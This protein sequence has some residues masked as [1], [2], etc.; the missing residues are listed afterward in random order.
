MGLTYWGLVSTP[1][2]FIPQQDMGYL[3][4]SVQ[5]PDASSKE[6]TEAVMKR[7]V[8][9]AK[10]TPGVWHATGVTGQSFVLNAFGSNFGSMFVNLEDYSERRDPTRYPADAIANHLRRSSPSSARGA[11][12]GVRS[13]AGARRGPG[14]R[15]HADGRGPRRR[16]LASAAGRD[17]KP[18][19]QRANATPGLVG[20]FTMFRANVPQLHVEP[21]MRACMCAR[22][23][24]AGLRRH[25]G[26]L[27]GIAVRQRLQPLRPHLAGERAGRRTSS[28]IRSRTTSRGCRCATTDGDGAARFAGRASRR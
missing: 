18:G 7:L 16:R 26:R 25:A 27:R 8:N 19:A 21:D 9:I 12:G 11:S 23:D 6:R 4:C 28:A 22:G 10:K 3:M 1:K 20:L 17:G 2:G 15:L 14:R 13:A 24:A 5:L